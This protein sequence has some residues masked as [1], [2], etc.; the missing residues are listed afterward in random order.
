M[1]SNTRL[2][3]MDGPVTDYAKE[4]REEAGVFGP[5]FTAKGPYHVSSSRSAVVVHFADIRSEADL[6]SLIGALRAAGAHS[7]AIK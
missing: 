3:I 6:E 7:A 5:F 2:T 4:F 1:K